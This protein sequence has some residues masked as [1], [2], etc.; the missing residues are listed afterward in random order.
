MLRVPC[1]NYY[2]FD[3]SISGQNRSQLATVAVEAVGH[4][5]GQARNGGGG[6]SRTAW[7]ADYTQLLRCIALSLRVR[8]GLPMRR[9]RAVCTALGCI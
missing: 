6:P 5:D 7:R 2:Q 4:S 1:Q 3:M 8:A 9:V